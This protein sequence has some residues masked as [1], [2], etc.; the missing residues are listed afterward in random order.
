MGPQGTEAAHGQQKM[1]QG[2]GFPREG[3][4]DLRPHLP[5]AAGRS[6]EASPGNPP[7]RLKRELPS[8][9][10]AL[11]GLSGSHWKVGQWRRGGARPRKMAAAEAALRGGLREGL[12]GLRERH[13]GWRE[14][15]AACLPLL[16]ALGNVARQAE[17]ARR[18]SFAETPLQAFAGLP[19]RLRV[20]QRAAMEALLAELRREKLPALREARDA[21][22]ARLVPLLAL[23][24]PFPAWAHMV[25]G[26]LDA[27]ALYHAVTWRRS[28][29]CSR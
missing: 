16:Q 28:C 17:A 2:S 7:P 1:Q 22:G 23:G 10:R 14:T 20:K 13:R 12:R 27:E 15:L 5:L 8:G 29:C 4:A 18:V 19:E 11:R 24:R 25:A 9:Q 21:V 3:G 26:L 6:G